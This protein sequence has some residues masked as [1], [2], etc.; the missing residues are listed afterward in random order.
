[1]VDL[2][3]TGQKRVIRRGILHAGWGGDGY[4]RCLGRREVDRLIMRVFTGI[5]ALAVGQALARDVSVCRDATYAVQGVPCVGLGDKPFGEVCPK[6]GDVAVGACRKGLPS[7]N[8]KGCVAPEDAVCAQVNGKVWGYTTNPAQQGT[9]EPT[10]PAQQGTPEPTNP[11]QQGTPKPTNPAQQGTPEP[12]NPA[13]QGTPEPTNPAQQGTPKPTNPAQ[14]GTPEPTNPAQQGT[15]EPTN[16]AQQGTPKPKSTNPAQQGTPEPTNPAQ[17]GTPKPKPTNPAQ[18]GTPNPAQQGVDEPDPAQQQQQGNPVQGPNQDDGQQQQQSQGAL[19][20]VSLSSQGNATSSDSTSAWVAGGAVAMVAVVIVGVFYAKKKREQRANDDYT[21]DAIL[22]PLARLKSKHAAPRLVHLLVHFSM[23]ATQQD[24]R[25]PIDAAALERYIHATLGAHHGAIDKIVQFEHGQS[26]PTYRIDLAG[27][28]AQVVLRKKPHGALLP[29][30]HAVEREYRVL[31]ALEHTQV[32]VP[33]PLALCEDVSVIGTPFY[34]MQFVPG[35]IFKDPTLRAVRNPLHRYAMYSAVCDALVE[36]HSLDY[37]A[38]GLDGFGQPAKY[39][40]RVLSRW[41]K[42]VNAGSKVFEK[43]GVAENAQMG[44]LRDWL[45]NHVDAAEEETGERA[46][47]VHGDFRI[48]NIIFHPTEPRIVA[49]LDW[50]LCTI[51]NPFVDVATLASSYRFPASIP[52]LKMV[53]PGLADLPVPLE[54]VGI[55]NEYDLLSGYCRRACRFPLEDSTWQFFLGLVCFKFAA[56]CHGVYARSLSGNASS[57]HAHQSKMAMDEV[58]KLGVKIV[59]SNVSLFPEP[60]LSQ[61]L[62]FPIRPHARELYKRVAAFCEQKIF[63]AEHLHLKELS[64]ARATGKIWSHIPDVLEKLKAE[65]RQL[66]LWNLFLPSGS[67]PSLHPGGKVIQYGADLTNLEYGLMCELMGRSIMFAPE[68]FN[69]SA[70]DTGNMEILSR[71]ATV[72]QKHEWLVPLL[73][74]RI[75]SCFA[76]TEKL[77]ASSDATNIQTSFVR[78]EGKKEYVINGRKFYISGVGDPRCKLVIVMG[79]VTNPKE[80]TKSPFRQQSMILVPM[81]TPGIEL[82]RPMEVFGYDDAPHGHFEMVFKNVRV[83]FENVLLGEGRGFEIAQARLGPGRIH[84]CMRAIGAAERC[85]EMMVHRAKTRTAFRQLLAEN[86]LVCS[87]IAKSRCELDSARLLTLQAAHQMDTRD[88]KAAAQAIAMIK[89]VAPNTALKICDR[90]I[91][92]HGAAGV[93]QDFVLAYY[94]AGLRTLRIADGPDEVHMRTIAKMEL[95]TSRL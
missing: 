90:A 61:S 73:E 74:G 80:A 86:P 9:P 72:K 30:A 62:P 70:P 77:V 85:L 46:T 10:N 65:A 24:V 23:V 50:E 83:P 19:Q 20:T 16:P 76:M 7:H 37:R 42:Q 29:S 51:G 78:D 82:V 41:T 84:H 8:G 11:A 5:L 68:I 28:G 32:P 6:K 15:P 45:L 71:F 48:D 89:I 12:T 53:L 69:C 59:S 13:Q 87:Q 1:M 58:L 36:L 40:Q 92:I 54:K 38:I 2:G 63:P 33:K 67:I 34:L 55:P 95:A 39:C 47:I 57:A 79:K 21:I 3:A 35:R 44:T 14:Q 26:N 66:G 56:I 17:Q 94:Y 4:T 27:S 75:R 60:E 52:G 64:E 49:I 31:C 91:Q 22:T 18:Q 43:A 25:A 93:S 88:N 81:S